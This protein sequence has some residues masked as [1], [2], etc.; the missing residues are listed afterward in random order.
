MLNYE[1]DLLDLP[2][3]VDV[4]LYDFDRVVGDTLVAPLA[5]GA[6]KPYK[7]ST[8]TL[9]PSGRKK[10][11][12][13]HINGFGY[14]QEVVEGA[15]NTRGLFGNY[16]DPSGSSYL[17]LDGCFNQNGESVLESANCNFCGSVDV[18]PDFPERPF[19]LFPNPADDEI[20]IQTRTGN[21]EHCHVKIVDLLGHVLFEKTG[22]NTDTAIS[23]A[24]WP[25][26]TCILSLTDPESGHSWVQ[27]FQVQH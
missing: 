1:N 12:L 21:A 17:P 7:V 8:I 9:L 10:F 5:G 27:K 18:R 22:F 2:S 25:P 13:T 11:K 16:S 3:G 24:N 20:S 23:T 19:I 26:Q 14:T 4:L 15:G 6:A